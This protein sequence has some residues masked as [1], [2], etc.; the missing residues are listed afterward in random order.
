[1]KIF[2]RITTERIQSFLESE[3]KERE[4]QIRKF[5]YIL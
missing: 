4:Q 2:E 5:S 1:L 3:E